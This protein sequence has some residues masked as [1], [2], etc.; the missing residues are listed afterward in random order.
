MKLPVGKL[1]NVPGEVMEFTLSLTPVADG[2]LAKATALTFHGKAE[3][4]QR[5]IR[6]EGE[7]RGSLVFPCD[8]CGESFVFPI[9]VAFSESFTNQA[10][11]DEENLHEFHGDEIDLT[12]YVEQAVFL[13]VPMKMLCKEDCLGLCPTCGTNLNQGACACENTVLDPRMAALAALLDESFEEEGG[14]KNGC[15]EG[16]D[17]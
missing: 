15:T 2:I 17:L 6:V 3:N 10:A 1:K 8:R 13:E 12:P 14:V 4:V 7:I 5:L 9:E 16:E 11:G